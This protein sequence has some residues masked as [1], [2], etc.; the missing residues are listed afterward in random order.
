[1]SS[2]ALA[3][4]VSGQQGHTHTRQLES[5]HAYLRTLRS[6]AA[7][8]ITGVVGTVLPYPFES[9]RLKL[10]TAKQ[11]SIVAQPR[12]FDRSLW[13]GLSGGL[14]QGVLL[15]GFNFGTYDLVLRGLVSA[16]SSSSFSSTS[17]PEAVPVMYVGN[18][19][20]THHILHK[21]SLS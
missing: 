15:R 5:Q 16:T 6:F 14:L 12:F 7:G 19:E 4:T 1:M 11:G 17:G 9:Y 21:P 2:L 3:M 10:L 18:K 13:K 20:K 8:A